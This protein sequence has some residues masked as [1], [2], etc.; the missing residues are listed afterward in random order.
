MERVAVGVDYILLAEADMQSP[1]VEETL[2]EG[3]IVAAEGGRVV[4][5]GRLRYILQKR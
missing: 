2:A 1:A 3:G 4:G 5:E